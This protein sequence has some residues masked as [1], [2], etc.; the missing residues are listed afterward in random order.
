MVEAFVFAVGFY[1]AYVLALFYYAQEGF[2]ALEV[3]ADY[4]VIGATTGVYEGSVTEIRVDL[5]P[6]QHA[7]KG[8]L[9][10]IPV[11]F[12]DDWKGERKLRRGDRLYLWEEEGA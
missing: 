2:I 3:G 5:K 10:S 1:C 4:M 8:D 7:G 11:V 6:V 12:P 9:C